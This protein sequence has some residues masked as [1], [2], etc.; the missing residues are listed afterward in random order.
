MND[1]YENIEEYNLNKKHKILIPFYDLIANM[2][3]NKKVNPIVT[4]LY[5]R[6]RKLNISLVFLH[7]PIFLNQNKSQTKFYTLFYYKNA[8]QTRVSTNRN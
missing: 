3:Y 1:I 6:G 8:K 7:N 5:I 4:E 2:V